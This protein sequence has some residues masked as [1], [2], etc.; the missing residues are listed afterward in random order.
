MLALL[1]TIQ[2]NVCCLLVPLIRKC[3]SE[4]DAFFLQDVSREVVRILI[5]PKHEIHL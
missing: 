5:L 2:V 1:V 4:A 3:S